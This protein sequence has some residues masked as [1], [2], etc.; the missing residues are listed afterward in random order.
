[1]EHELRATIQFIHRLG[2]L[3]T[4]SYL[5][6]LSVLLLRQKRQRSL[7][8]AGGI[9]LILLTA[10]VALGIIN[11]LYFLPLPVA[12]GHN[13]VAAML[14]AMLLSLLVLVSGRSQNAA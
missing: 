7:Q 9:L 13:A 8:T 14:M 5:V 11:A 1:M 4:A 12:V 6:F 3:I 2:A 10:Q